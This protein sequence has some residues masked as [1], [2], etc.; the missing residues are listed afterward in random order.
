MS[1]LKQ[2]RTTTTRA[3]MKAVMQIDRTEIIY[4]DAR[5]EE[6]GR[7]PVAQSKRYSMQAAMNHRKMEKFKKAHS[8]VVLAHCDGGRFYFT[9]DGRSW[10]K[11]HLWEK[12]GHAKKR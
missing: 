6:V 11:S 1:K 12:E 4:F 2:K 9:D 7:E 10:F 5:D 3:D 8:E